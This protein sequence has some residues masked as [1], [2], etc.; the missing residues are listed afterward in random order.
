[1]QIDLSKD[2]ESM[3]PAYLAAYRQA[4]NRSC[5]IAQD[6][7]DNC[8]LVHDPDRMA[9]LLFENMKLYGFSDNEC[10]AFL[11]RFETVFRSADSATPQRGESK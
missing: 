3:E 10:Q 7:A 1:M 2:F 5:K 8:F 11:T 9:D 6:I 4:S